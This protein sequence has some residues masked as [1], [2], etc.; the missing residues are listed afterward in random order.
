[1]NTLSAA[2]LFSI[3]A[4]ASLTAAEE[5]AEYRSIYSQDA[6]YEAIRSNIYD[7]HLAAAQNSIDSLIA[8]NP[9]DPKPYFFMTLVRWWYFL[10][11]VN[12]RSF[13]TSF[14]KSAEKTV[15]TGKKRVEAREDDVNALFYLGGAY[16]Y[17]AR[18]Y[19]FTNEWL[20]AYYYGRKAKNI[21]SDMLEDNDT[22]YDAQLAVGVYNYYADELP[23]LLKIFT[24]IFGLSGDKRLGL[25]Q[26]HLAAD[27][28][29]Y[30]RVEALSMLGFVNLELENNY[31]EA[32]AMFTGLFAEHM[33]NPVF[34]ML[35]SDSYR[36][37]KNYE[38]AI[39]ICTGLLN[40]SS[41]KYVSVNQLAGLH[42]ELA[43]CQ[44]LA[45]NY[46]F[47]IREYKIC[48][49]LAV[50]DYVRESPWIYFNVG[51]CEENE[52]N[53]SEAVVYYSKVLDCRDYFGYHSNARKAIE[54][55]R[56]EHGAGH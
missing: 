5:P 33:S 47:A 20:D 37:L 41:I 29:I 1:M 13:R 3:V 35:L 10:G 30:S 43:Y 2:L 23:A 49:S 54:R 8:E 22:L 18:Y 21:F 4:C 19:V 11:D 27:S 28:G 7:Y 24:S 17:L 38:R 48:D 16:G 40:D 34:G 52:H 32:E 42:A 14:L 25:R 46:A 26:L 56:S 15:E 51:V 50:D 55:I 9:D 45:R 44:M 53:F 12:S 31:Q 39:S 6:R 36:K